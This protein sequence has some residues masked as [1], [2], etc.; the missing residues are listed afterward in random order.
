MKIFKHAENSELFRLDEITDNQIIALN[1][2]AKNYHAYLNTIIKLPDA[3]LKEFAPGESEH[4][5]MAMRL[6]IQ[7]CIAYEMAFS[8]VVNAG[9]QKKPLA[10]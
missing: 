8:D 2:I 6:Q 1:D 9:E 4:A 10:N 7:T 5:R 3:Q